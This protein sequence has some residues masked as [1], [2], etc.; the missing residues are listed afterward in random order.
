V[1]NA[2][3]T[4]G[5][6]RAMETYFSAQGKP[7]R[8]RVNGS[9]DVEIAG[10]FTMLFDRLSDRVKS[11]VIAGYQ[12]VNWR[13]RARDA[14]LA[15]LESSLT[16]L[17]PLNDPLRGQRAEHLLANISHQLERS[18]KISWRRAL[19]MELD[20]L[21]SS[22]AGAAMSNAIRLLVDIGQLGHPALEKQAI[23]AIGAQRI[24]FAVLSGQ[25]QQAMLSALSQTIARHLQDRHVLPADTAALGADALLQAM[26]AY[27]LNLDHAMKLLDLPASLRDKDATPAADQ[28]ESLILDGI[29]RAIA[30]HTG[31]TPEA[32]RKGAKNVEFC[33][34][35]YA[36]DWK[37]ALDLVGLTNRLAPRLHALRAA[38]RDAPAQD[39]PAKLRLGPAEMDC[40]RAVQQVMARDHC[41]IDTAMQVVERRL[42]TLESIRPGLPPRAMPSIVEGLQFHLSSDISESSKRYLADQIR[43]LDNAQKKE[44]WRVPGSTTDIPLSENYLMDSIRSMRVALDDGRQVS[45]FDERNPEGLTAAVYAL[46]KDAKTMTALCDSINQT[47][48]ASILKIILKM[49]QHGG[50]GE[51]LMVV[52]G[53]D[54]PGTSAQRL[55]NSITLDGKG[56]V[57]VR[58]VFIQKTGML[59][60]PASGQTW[61]INQG[62]A[63]DGDVSPLSAGLTYDYSYAFDL[64]DLQKGKRE[65]Q[66]LDCRYTIAGSL[67]WESIDRM[68][69]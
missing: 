63:W 54:R 36:M 37:Q 16:A 53:E 41:D 39:R 28:I 60:T 26:Q 12:P 62:P 69:A 3:G 25:G 35:R 22:D 18:D 43:L 67:D 52:P 11:L 58:H 33:M 15:K 17:L 2:I 68:P 65:P 46:A 38:G 20:L 23:A 49:E 1:T 34:R 51:Q 9:G 56:K 47:L 14:V 27:D 4:Q 64:A 48:Q 61:P 19:A 31:V 55:W 6:L 5:A 40:A 13:E 59:I 45:Y 24:D 32:A 57:I 66:I 10:R 44:A 8:L 7:E 42:K 29:A 21:R 50:D 30:R